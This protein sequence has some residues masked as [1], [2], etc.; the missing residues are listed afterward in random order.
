[1]LDLFAEAEP[2]QEPLAPGAVI[3]R[4]FALTHAKALFDGINDVA[5]I[6][7]FRHMVTPGGYTMSV[8]MTN[9]GPLGWATNARGYLYAP[10]DPA[11]GH[12]WPPVP[13]AFE[14]LCHEAAIEAGYPE[15]QPDACLINRYAVGAKLS[16]HQDKDEPDLRAPIVSVSLG[17]PAVFQFG[18]LKRSDPLKR[19]MLEH[20]DVVVWG[21]ESRL[22]YHGI[23]PLKPGVHPMTGEYRYNL[24]FR[25]A[26]YSE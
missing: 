3:L 17:L 12:P 24:T 26:A 19:L 13:A 11:T 25:Q 14:A 20:G 4:R 10:K 8:A 22:Y 7:P 16:L 9:C 5:A 2:W 6:S 23:Q 18:G 1:M 21:R 15:F